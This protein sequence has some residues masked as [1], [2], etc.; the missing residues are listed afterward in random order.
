MS[1]LLGGRRAV[2]GIWSGAPVFQPK[3]DLRSDGASRAY[4]NARLYLPFID[5]A[6]FQA[7]LTQIEDLR[8][9]EIA[10]AFG[11]L[12][13]GAGSGSLGYVDF[14]VLGVSWSYGDR[15]Q[16][17]ETVGDA[18]T[19]YAFG[20]SPTQLGL[21]GVLYNTRQDNWLDAMHYAWTYAVR[22]TANART[23][24][25]LH[26][27]LG[28]HLMQVAAVSYQPSVNAQMEMMV[29]FS[30]NFTILRHLV[31]PGRAN[32]R[33][34]LLGE[35]G[36][37]PKEFLADQAEASRLLELAAES[38]NNLLI[39][40]GLFGPPTAQVLEDA[41]LGAADG[42][43]QSFAFTGPLRPEDEPGPPQSTIVSAFTGPL[44]GADTQGPPAPDVP[45]QEGESTAT[46]V[47]RQ[48]GTLL[49][50]QNEERLDQLRATGVVPP[51]P[52]LAVSASG[53]GAVRTLPAAAPGLVGATGQTQHANA[54]SGKITVPR[55][56]G[57]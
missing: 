20:S 26:L 44:L 23:R 27:Q 21:R 33:P 36:G 37:P 50:G 55:E 45:Q 25:T 8:G 7:W 5:Q 12:S 54:L 31:L 49:A 53:G 56:S 6:A 43:G 11:V 51:E 28:S 18:A 24:T 4:S 22:V 39:R 57:P 15:M 3:Y 1:E 42:R 38:E 9:R 2:R 30:M 32:T 41:L 47:R 14:G 13:D 19:F 46:Y 16:V 17:T 40:Q 35:L 34:T 10:S 29:E 52:A 48:G